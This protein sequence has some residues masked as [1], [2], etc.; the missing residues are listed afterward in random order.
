MAVENKRLVAEFAEQD[1]DEL[2]SMESHLVTFKVDDEEY[3]VPIMQVQEIIRLGNITRIPG[4]PH[5]VE[6]VMDLRDKV[7]P[8]VDL[9]K[10][11]RLEQRAQ[12]GNDNGRI[13]VVNLGDMTIGLVVDEI[14]EVLRLPNN[15]VEPPPRIVAGIDSRFLKGIGRLERRLLIL[16]DLDRIFSEDELTGL[17]QVVEEK[18]A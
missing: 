11:F 7:L 12:N 15:A 17:E 4:S 3:G 8:V 14:S 2:L 1:E 18:G 9:R 16:L 10:R 13:V 6:G 5:F